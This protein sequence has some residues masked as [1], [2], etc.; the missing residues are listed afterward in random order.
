M[1]AVLLNK[2]SQPLFQNLI[3]PSRDNSFSD[4]PTGSLVHAKLCRELDFRHTNALCQIAAPER[5]EGE[6]TMKL[7]DSE[8]L[9]PESAIPLTSLS[10]ASR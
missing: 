2:C 8:A 6:K 1:Y 10:P 5:A 9:P 7:S 4:W 3:S